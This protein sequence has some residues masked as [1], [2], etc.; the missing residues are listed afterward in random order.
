MFKDHKVRLL[1]RAQIKRLLITKLGEGYARPTVTLILSTVRSLLNSALEDGIITSNPS[2]KL[3]RALKLE[4]PPEGNVNEQVKA[5]TREEL[6]RF[7]EAAKQAP[8]P[9][10]PLFWVLALTGARVGEGI[11]LRWSDLDLS[12]RSLHIQRTLSE[13]LLSTPKS[14]RDRLVLLSKRAATV[15]QRLQMTRADRAKRLRW[16]TPPEYIFIAGEGTPPS[17]YNIREAFMDVLQR[18]GLPKHHTP[19]SLRHTYASL[20]LQNGESLKFVQEQ[21]GHSTIKLT[22]DL[23]GKW[24]KTE[25]MRGGANYLDAMTRQTDSTSG[26][27][28][29]LETLK[30]ARIVAIGGGSTSSSSS[31]SCSSC[32]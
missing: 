10:G 16:K 15:L 26:S 2:A 32:R 8:L 23:Y 14:G 20:L 22:A 4:A 11:A 19:H 17:K 21:L 24:A 29:A 18:A 28:K 6:A 9:Y 5:F 7:F 27:R 31:S 13:G 30:G 3:G 12:Q 25:P 1:T